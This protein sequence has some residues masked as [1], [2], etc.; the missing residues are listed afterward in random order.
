[1][2]GATVTGKW[3]LTLSRKPWHSLIVRYVFPPSWAGSPVT[4]SSLRSARLLL[5]RSA[6][7]RSQITA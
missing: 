2:T 1:M 5:S 3:G 4:G 7:R 6:L